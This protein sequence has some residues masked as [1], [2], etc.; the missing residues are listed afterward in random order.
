MLDQR[1]GFRHGPP[2]WAVVGRP[3]AHYIEC[4]LPAKRDRSPGWRP[5]RLP[6][7]VRPAPPAWHSDVTRRVDSRDGA[8]DLEP[9]R[10]SMVGVRAGG[11]VRRPGC[12]PD[13]EDKMALRRERKL[14][15]PFVDVELNTTDLSTAKHFYGKM[16]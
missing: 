10:S 13:S 4:G 3:L 2:P 5:S 1:A 15:H 11:A 7:L 9:S 12:D 14:A 8:V 6:P 16:F